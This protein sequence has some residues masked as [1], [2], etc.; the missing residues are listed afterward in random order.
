M[1]NEMMAA[2]LR[3]VLL[4]ICPTLGT[5]DLPA[6]DEQLQ[7]LWDRVCDMPALVKG[8]TSSSPR[9]QS[10]PACW[11]NLLKWKA[12]TRKNRQTILAEFA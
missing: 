6:G 12:F 11:S 8:A 7:S 3:I 9:G 1:Y 4:P 10:E 5:P 2:L